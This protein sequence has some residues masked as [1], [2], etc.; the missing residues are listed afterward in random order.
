MWQLCYKHF[1]SMPSRR[2][3]SI[4]DPPSL[5]PSVKSQAHC[6]FSQAFISYQKLCQLYD[7]R[8]ICDNQA[9]CPVSLA[10][11][12]CVT[13]LTQFKSPTCELWTEIKKIKNHLEMSQILEKVLSY[14]HYL[15]NFLLKMANLSKIYTINFPI[16]S[17]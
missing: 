11:S 17:C 12:L 8:Y 7:E 9:F 5:L 13:L 14:N 16:K 10:L 4:C 1:I 3:W 2:L 6:F 15:L